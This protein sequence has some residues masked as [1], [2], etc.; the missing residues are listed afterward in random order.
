MEISEER[1]EKVSRVKMKGRFDAHTTGEVEKFL[2]EIIKDGRH[3]IILNMHEV[4]FIASAGLR[5][6]LVL[7]RELR[8]E[9]KGDLRLALLQPNVHRVFEISGLNNVISI[10]RD[11]G[12]AT[13]S[14]STDIYKNPKPESL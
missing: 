12:T 4:P 6:V 2:R 8:K 13:L 3:C 11:L 10:F 5:I 7:A 14:F 1:L 9:H